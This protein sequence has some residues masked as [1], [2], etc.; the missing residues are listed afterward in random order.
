MSEVLEHLIPGLEKQ[1]QSNEAELSSA[2]LERGY[3]N[4]TITDK[5]MKVHNLMESIV[6]N[7]RVGAFQ[8]EIRARARP[9]RSIPLPLFL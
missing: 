8:T 2:R 1:I 7:V 9:A 3:M 4:R 5:Y 6:M